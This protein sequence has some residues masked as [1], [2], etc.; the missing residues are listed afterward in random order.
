ML[1]HEEFQREWT[2]AFVDYFAWTRARDFEI[3]FSYKLHRFSMS[4]HYMPLLRSITILEDIRNKAALQRINVELR[5]DSQSFNPKQIY[6]IEVGDNK[7]ATL[8]IRKYNNNRKRDLKKSSRALIVL[9]ASR[10]KS[11]ETTYDPRFL[12]FYDSF[13]KSFGTPPFPIG[14]IRRL[15]ETSLLETLYCYDSSSME[16]KGAVFFSHID[17]E[18]WVP[19]IVYD[20]KCLKLGIS[21]LLWHSAINEGYKRECRIVNL[22]TSYKMSGPGNFKAS[23]G[24]SIYEPF[25]NNGSNAN[26]AKVRF[27][28]AAKN[29][30]V[31]ARFR[32]YFM[33]RLFSY[34]IWKYCAHYV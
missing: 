2:N 27:Q 8:P 18:L 28:N 7:D 10:E 22:G 6:Y 20:K 33:L 29:L 13:Y 24:A 17:D 15:M 26:P 4:R 30:G 12:E 32:P 5:K 1:T 14:L 3:D 16:I 25:E 31:N 11:L 9:T 19:W 21:T 23:L 34:Y